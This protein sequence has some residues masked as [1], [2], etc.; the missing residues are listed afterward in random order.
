MSSALLGIYR[1][2]GAP[3]V[4]GH[5]SRLLMEDGREVVDFVS[6][7]AVNALGYG[8]PGVAAAISE[9]VAG[10]VLHTS[11]LYRTRP[12]ELLAEELVRHSFAD[13]VFFCNSGA[14]SNEAAFKFA[15]RWARERGGPAKHEIVALRGS[16]HGRLFG[17]LAATDRPAYRE[18]FEPLAPGFHFVSPGDE[19]GLMAAVSPERTAALIAEPVQGEGGVRPLSA[20]ELQRLREVADQVGA[21]LILDEVQCGLGRTGRLFAYEEAGVVP[22]ILTLAKPLAGGLPMGAVLLTD[23]IASTLRP[24]DHG[25]TFGGGPLVSAVALV[26]LQRI[27]EPA[28][29]A[30]VRHKGERVLE[31]LTPFVGRYGIREVR[32]RGLLVGIELEG[33]AAPVVS[34]AFEAGL[35]ITTAGEKVLRLLPPLAITEAELETGLEILLE[36]L[37][38]A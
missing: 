34:R 5:G 35:L 12:A 8:D 14:E 3:I 23:E 32:G 2:L 25:T 6:G 1:P 22:D 16:F 13:R 17:T 33:A 4:G 10:G 28:F 31:T 30:A 26:V 20:S 24:G 15:R 11:N 18:P 37:A 29:L 36:V 38:W 9:V 27:S 19:A 7:I 21:A